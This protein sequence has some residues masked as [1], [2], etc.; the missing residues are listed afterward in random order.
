MCIRDRVNPI[1]ANLSSYVLFSN[2]GQIMAKGDVTNGLKIDVSG[3]NP[4]VY[5]INVVLV[6][7]K[8]LSQKVVVQ[9]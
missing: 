2:S 4:G 6:D 9:R 5:V 7:G 3:F 8:T 1:Q